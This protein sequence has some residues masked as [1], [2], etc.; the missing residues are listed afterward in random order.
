MFK[1][2]S[3]VT[4]CCLLVA[5]DWR[6]IGFLVGPL[7]GSLFA[8]TFLLASVLA[9]LLAPY[10]LPLAPPG[11]LLVAAILGPVLVHNWPMAL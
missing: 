3:P 7:V 1:H 8:P 6:P 4:I 11:G 5:P 10:L 9:H 2:M